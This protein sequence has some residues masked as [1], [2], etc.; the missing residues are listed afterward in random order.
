M[1]KKGKKDARCTDSLTPAQKETKWNEFIEAYIECGG[2][3]YVAAKKLG[4]NNETIG[5][6]FA[7][8]TFLDLVAKV[9]E[10]W[11]E[12]LRSVAM[13]RARAKSDI[14][15]IFLLK[16]IRPDLYD[17]EI[18]KQIYMNT[19]G[20]QDQ[21][22]APIRAI[23]VREEAAIPGTIDITQSEDAQV[24]FPVREWERDPGE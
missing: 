10:R 11:H 8:P 14:L 20:L 2:Q 4:L 16:S 9:N 5:K 15:L 22:Q 17:D 24:D 23:L 3:R 13:E 18:R 7:E 12:D 6:Y 1:T 19:H 21:N